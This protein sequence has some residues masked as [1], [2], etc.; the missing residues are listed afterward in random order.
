MNLK[1]K[2]CKVNTTITTTTITITTITTITTMST[3]EFPYK[4]RYTSESVI[5]QRFDNL[6][7]TP[8]EYID[9]DYRIN[10]IPLLDT[11]DLKFYSEQTE[12]GCGLVLVHRYDD[13]YFNEEISD[14]FIEDIRIDAKRWDQPLTE[15]EWWDKNSSKFAHL[16]LKA[17]SDA[18]Y[19]GMKHVGVFKPFN[20]LAFMR[21]FGSSRVLDFS[22]G[23]GDRMIGFL[24]AKV[25]NSLYVG[26][27]PNERLH[28]EYSRMR[29]FFASDDSNAQVEMICG[30]FE[31]PE[32]EIPYDNFDMIFTSPPYFHL[33]I[34]S[35][36]TTGKNAQSSRHAS[37]DAWFNEFLVIALQK[38]W[39]ALRIGGVMCININ[40][41][42]KYPKDSTGE[43][44]AYTQRMIEYIN[45]WSDSKFLGCI[46]YGTALS[47]R[48][49]PLKAIGNKILDHNPQPI[50]IW[51]KY[52]PIDTLTI[53]PRVC[54]REINYC[55]KIIRVCDESMLP[56]GTKQ[57]AFRAFRDM[58]QGGVRELIYC[59]YPTGAAASALAVIAKYYSGCSGYQIRAR[60]FTN[61]FGR[62]MS[63]AHMYGCKIVVCKG[64]SLRELG[65]IARDYV[66]SKGDADA[67]SKYIVEFGFNDEKFINAI[68][69]EINGNLSIFHASASAIVPSR[70]WLVAGSGTI[71]KVLQRITDSSVKFNVLLMNGRK[72]DDSDG[73]NGS[74]TVTKISE[75]NILKGAARLPPYK[76]V[77]SYDAKVWSW[78]T[79]FVSNFRSEVISDVRVILAPETHG[80]N[81]DDSICNEAHIIWNT[82]GIDDPLQHEYRRWEYVQKIKEYCLRSFGTTTSI[83]QTNKSAQ[84][85]LNNIIERFLLTMANSARADDDVILHGN[86]AEAISTFESEYSAKFRR[87]FA[88]GGL[89]RLIGEFCASCIQPASRELDSRIV[90]AEFASTYPAE[91]IKLLI[92]RTD[93]YRTG[94]MLL[95][96]A[97]ILPGGQHW[98]APRELYAKYHDI[99]GCRIEG[100]AS[101]VN[102]QLLP[103]TDSA[104]CSLFPD[105]D[106][107]WGSLGGF[108]DCDWENVMYDKYRVGGNDGTLTI[109]VGPPFID[110][111]LTRIA[112]TII[113]YCKLGEISG[114]KIRFLFTHA[115]WKDHRAIIE[116]LNS[117]YLRKMHVFGA[118]KHYYYNSNLATNEKILAQFDTILLILDSGIG[119]DNSLNGNVIKG[120]F[121]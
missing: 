86:Y 109:A 51:R 8:H 119:N 92:L 48:G 31:S 38:A 65:E 94:I 107:C 85:E 24:A 9:L 90:C 95:R 72:Y 23:W 104:F 89:I 78:I 106:G 36:I 67:S 45:T 10:N 79:S 60:M 57:R 108:F 20:M 30:A 120:L 15:R 46:A 77:A 112:A 22:S 99:F 25:P 87:K 11:H 63:R 71:L 12:S 93:E 69:A 34:Y 53:S 82:A 27:D 110:C 98:N 114:K 118:R 113:K 54:I 39:S 29:E 43:N 68:A 64:K 26:V 75:S 101:P 59:G 100:F 2:D 14:W 17:Q 117:K 7:N 21:L 88:S 44:P 105:V 81:D 102:S 16:S 41:Y 52:S 32:V 91:R 111:L 103:Y 47:R 40:D 74:R 62:F 116:L 121:D 42:A 55:G 76:S 13:Y 37:L 115:Y 1:A 84:Y 80:K 3:L 28:A 5:R 19:R 35:N 73:F 97:C 33:E 56:G 83:S 66:D 58:I 6:V 49:E 18:I 61:D 96:Y 50:W 70:I 4:R